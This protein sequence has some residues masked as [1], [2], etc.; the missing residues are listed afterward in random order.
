[1]KK[2]LAKFLEVIRSFAESYRTLNET[3]YAPL[4]ARQ[5]T[6]VIFF[7]VLLALYIATIITLSNFYTGGKDAIFLW[8][9]LFCVAYQGLKF[10]LR[11]HGAW[12]IHCKKERGKLS[13]KTFLVA[14]SI[15]FIVCMANLFAHYP[16]G[17]SPDNISQW[18]QVQSENFDNWHPAIHTMLIWL[19]THIVPTYSFF[20]GFQITFFCM[21]IGYMYAT[22]QVWG[23]KKRWSVF[24]LILAVTPLPTR[25]IV[26]HAWKDTASTILLLF[27][28]VCTINIVLSGGKW[29]SKWNNVLAIAVVGA[30]ASIVR[31]NGFFFTLPFGILVAACYTKV[32][33]NALFTIAASIVL[34]LGITKVLYPVVGVSQSKTQRYIESVG[35]PM[36]ILSG[37]MSR[38]PERLDDETRAFLTGIATEEQWREVFRHGNYNSVKWPFDISRFIEQIPPQK[39]LQMTLRT[40]RAVPTTSLNE[41]IALTKMV[42]HPVDWR[43]GIGISGADGTAYR[44]YS[45]HELDTMRPVIKTSGILYGF[46]DTIIKMVIPSFIFSSIGLNMLLL[47][48]A[49]VFSVN[50]NLGAKALVLFIPSVAYNLGTML[51]LSGQDYRFFHFNIVITLPL[52]I[53]LL[54]KNHEISPQNDSA[55]L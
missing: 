21:A 12:Y 48:L 27:L 2:S 33:R 5:R 26:L 22:L 3:V 41:V 23:I 28:A 31:H 14:S 37:V 54:A 15:P 44:L 47:L 4:S 16:G 9:I 43:Y 55:K 8:P 19:V 30:L 53:V 7:N 25:N 38:E 10:L 11:K 39:L 18:I 24:F 51:L 34:V 50:R 42:W 35:L 32:T 46:I 49:G 29:L 40:I 13:L 6:V 20:I 45:E 52:I 36:T 17:I 1:M